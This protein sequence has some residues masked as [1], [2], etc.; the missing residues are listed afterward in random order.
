MSSEERENSQKDSPKIKLLVL[1]PDIKMNNSDQSQ[2][3]ATKE[4]QKKRFSISTAESTRPLVRSSIGNSRFRVSLRNSHL[5]QKRDEL[6]NLSQ[7][8]PELV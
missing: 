8:H 4:K 2:S 3:Q 5:S 6:P 7:K 1:H